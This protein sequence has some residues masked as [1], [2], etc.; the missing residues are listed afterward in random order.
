MARIRRIS[1]RRILNSRA[2]YTLEVT[3]EA[4]DATGVA[5][6]PAGASVG[7]HE[8]RALPADKAVSNVN[9]KIA[10]LLKGMS[11]INQEAIDNKMIKKDGTKNKSRF[12]GNAVLGVSLACARA[13]AQASEQEL[14]EY[15]TDLWGIKAPKLP[16]P[17]MNI[18]N[19]GVHAP[20]KL[21]IQEFMVAPVG[22]KSFSDAMDV[23]VD[24]YQALK[25]VLSKKY[26]KAA[27]N[28]GDEGGFA[29]PLKRSREALDALMKALDKAGKG[30]VAIAMDSA[31]SEF[32]KGRVYH[33]DGKRLSRD[34]L[35]GFYERLVD[36]Y[37]IVSLEDPFAES[38]WH[39]FAAITES[40][41][42]DIQI[43][44][45][46]IFATNMKLVEKGVR[47]GAANCMLLK[48]N[49]IGTLTESLKA[50]S[51]CLDNDYNVM[52]S[53]RSGETNDS[54][55]ADLAVGIGCGQIK[56]GA[57]C[58]GER[59]AKYNRLLEI[60]ASGISF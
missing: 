40:I 38:D 30:K 5:S 54:F 41:G 36:D 13:G 19:G 55:I 49:Q 42:Q 1:A 29:P 60:E 35:L 37:P 28:V 57:P 4:G 18:I 50:A 12:G 7:S 33:I 27:I 16:T 26:G 31:A 8:A 21:A 23:G 3:V 58:R 9:K 14:Y 51:F 46:D 52:V 43:I 59:T 2:Q 47:R 15:I 11:V 20:G 6:V 10:P 24:V 32:Y 25:G 45:D 53:H 22:A 44:G 56:A 17:F 39:G 48:P 34:R